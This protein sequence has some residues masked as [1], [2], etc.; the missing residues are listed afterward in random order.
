MELTNCD[1]PRGYVRQ[2]MRTENL[3][4]RGHDAINEV[5]QSLIANLPKMPP[6]HRQ[7]VIDTLR[8]NGVQF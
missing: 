3:K 2:N 1:S 7:A 6:E 5:R 8:L 4:Q